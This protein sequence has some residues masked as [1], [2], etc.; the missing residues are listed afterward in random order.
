[1]RTRELSLTLPGLYDYAVVPRLI[2]TVMWLSL[3]LSGCGGTRL[4]GPVQVDGR[5]SAAQGERRVFTPAELDLLC[6]AYADRYAAAL[7]SACDA[8]AVTATSTT[9]RSAVRRQALRLKLES[10]SA[11]YDIATTDDPL[12]KLLDLLMVVT[13]QSQAWI[14]DD[15]AGQWFGVG[16]GP[17]VGAIRRQ[18]QE[19]WALAAQVLH[20]AQL[21]EIDWLVWEWRRAHPQVEAISFVRFS[22]VAAGAGRALAADIHASGL[23]AP[24]NDALKAADDYRRLAERT[25]Y[26]A[27]RQPFLLAWHA[28]LMVDTVFEKNEIAT[29][30][31]VADRVV[32]F[33]ERIPALV[34]RER[35]AVM[36]GFIE[37]RAAVEKF[38]AE[39]RQTIE[40]TRTLVVDTKGLAETVRGTLSAV[41]TATTAATTTVGA[42]N[43]LVRELKPAPGSP[44]A[45]GASS[46]PFDIADYVV[47]AKELTATVRELTQVITAT[48][49]LI[50]SRAW[51]ERLGEVNQAAAERVEHATG[52]AERILGASFW[53]AAAIIT[54]FFAMLLAYRVLTVRLTRERK[55]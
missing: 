8:T 18:R 22:D 44:S 33:A 41:G 51:T 11:V 17:I 45:L 21:Q 3:C 39:L 19:I 6:G 28:E 2:I 5:L 29:L 35:T 52:Q 47:A 32:T 42:V 26:L 4:S 20:P 16:D 34:E 37:H 23:L 54:V 30:V 31:T 38:L 15:L 27:K 36:T 53:R 9:T 49:T 10:V 43:E 40:S 50:K 55:P 25:L 7:I 13:V 46:K 24:L 12:I 1:M 14:D 48:D